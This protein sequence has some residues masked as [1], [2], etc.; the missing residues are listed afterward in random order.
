[1]K[2]ILGLLFNTTILPIVRKVNTKI[3]QNITKFEISDMH[4]KNA[5]LITTREEL[6]RIL[7][8][9]G[10]VGELGVD[11]GD[12][13]NLILTINKP[14]KLH[15][16]DFWGSKRYNQSKRIKVENRFKKEVENKIVEINLGLS[17]EVVDDFKDNYFDWIYIDTSH[18]YE[19]TIQEL[20]L[21]RNKVKVDG[22]IA[23]HD[24][25]LGNW[26]GLVRYGVIEAVN[27]FCVKYNWEIIYLTTELN[28]NPSFAI[29]KITDD[30]TKFS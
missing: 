25:I 9:N 1:M 3:S 5:S 2:K 23:G 18:S 6:L 4:I 11:E 24:Y 15:L 27:E 20:T 26:N 13:S 7:P 17:T 10:V 16:I 29:R 30:N 8:K 12:F 19:T 14:K 22:V 21:Y 28:N